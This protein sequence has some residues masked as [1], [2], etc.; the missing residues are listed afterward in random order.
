MKNGR[1]VVLALI[2]A[3]AVWAS[4]AVA[5]A[6]AE[7]RSDWWLPPTWMQVLAGT[8][9]VALNVWRGV[10]QP[11]TGGAEPLAVGSA[12]SGGDHGTRW[13]TWQ[14]GGLDAR[15]LPIFELVH[16]GCVPGAS[17]SL[18]CEWYGEETAEQI[19]NQN[20]VTEFAD[21]YVASPGILTPNGSGQYVVWETDANSQAAHGPIVKISKSQEAGGGSR[22]FTGFEWVA[23][24]APAVTTTTLLCRSLGDTEGLGDFQVTE[25]SAPGSTVAPSPVC[26]SG[27]YAVR[28][29]VENSVDGVLS[30]TSITAPDWYLFD[31]SSV[32]IQAGIGPNRC[33]AGMPECDELQQDPENL[34][35]PLNGTCWAKQENPVYWTSLVADIDP[36]PGER[37][38]QVPDEWCLSPESPAGAVPMP[39]PP[40]TPT[41]P[42]QGII[43]RG[44]ERLKE[45]VEDLGEGMASGFGKVA[46]GIKGL[47]DKIAEGAAGTAGAIGRAVTPDAGVMSGLGARAGDALGEPFRPWTDALGSI[48]AAFQASSDGCQ[49]PA[50]TI[51]GGGTHYPFQSCSGPQATIAGFVY[52]ATGAAVVVL[53]V[54]ACVRLI[55]SSL[56]LQIGGGTE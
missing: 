1:R 8:A 47:G 48:P 17:T 10:E 52:V 49:G 42:D 4:V 7:E 55:G 12:G 11:V 13:Y 26:P 38:E 46:S 40:E 5:P 50:W 24:A 18:F 53:G 36:V 41:D 20:V 30:D 16:L 27:S 35:N 51:P 21:G 25:S 6:R 32:E 37:W 34:W 44:L 22:A 31:P 45:A 3:V 9:E 15:G 43:S 33:I 54:L 39:E 28:I 29:T 2:V 23:G 14:S 56:G 19:G